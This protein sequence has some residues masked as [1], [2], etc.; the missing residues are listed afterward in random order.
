MAALERHRGFDCLA[1]DVAEK[2]CADL[3]QVR[4]HE[5]GAVRGKAGGGERGMV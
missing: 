5:G 3:L 4:V 1:A 2:R